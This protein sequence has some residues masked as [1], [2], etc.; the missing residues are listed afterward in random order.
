MK[1]N[2]WIAWVAMIV[3]LLAACGDDGWFAQVGDDAE[4]ARAAN[5]RW[6]EQSA[7]AWFVIIEDCV[8]TSIWVDA[9]E[10]TFSW[11]SGQPDRWAGASAYLYRED[12]C[13]GTWYP[14]TDAWGW[15]TLEAGAFSM[16]GNLAE[17]RLRA[18]IPAYDYVSDVEFDIEVDLTWTGDGE[19]RRFK[20]RWHYDDGTTKE[21]SRYDS[22][23]READV[24]GTMTV[25][26]D[27]TVSPVSGSGQMT[28]ARSAFGST[29]SRRPRAPTIEYFEVYPHQ[30]YEGREADL[31]WWVSGT[32]P[33]T[34]SIDNGVGDVTGTDWVQVAPAVTTTYTLT[35]TNSRGSD[36][37]QVTVYVVPPPE[38]D[39]FEPNDSPA[40]ATAV[41]LDF[42][43]PELRIVPGDVDWFRF[44]LA[45]PATVVADVDAYEIGSSLDPLLVLLD[46]NHDVIAVND[47]YDGLD[48]RIEIDLDA[49]TY[50]LAVTAFPDFDANGDHWSDG[51]YYLEISALP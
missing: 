26:P 21:R 10:S 22:R 15:A 30:I 17:A 7:Y 35:A 39:E 19:L 4:A 18:T 50:Y 33:I 24:L 47:D 48:P 38:P 14:L 16:H 12:T 31:Y 3:L 46:E 42:S 25:D 34:L 51:F 2:V 43:S 9:R 44:T 13:S 8:E 27:G 28:D 45:A 11:G 32:D 1:T 37:A 40:D 36:S 6:T 20:D 5:S 23:S 29:E 49:G 41:E